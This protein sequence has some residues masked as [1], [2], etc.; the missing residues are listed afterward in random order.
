VSAKFIVKEMGRRHN[1]HREQA[2]E[3][4][5]ARWVYGVDFGVPSGLF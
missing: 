3:C 2:E 1:L 4:G 5:D